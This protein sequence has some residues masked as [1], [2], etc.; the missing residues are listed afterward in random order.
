VAEQRVTNPDICGWKKAQPLL[1]QIKSQIQT[2][3]EPPFFPIELI[4]Q[5]INRCLRRR[6]NDEGL[7]KANESFSEVFYL[8]YFPFCVDG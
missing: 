2:A 5:Y 6:V 7:I 4:E 8:W 3:S 1:E